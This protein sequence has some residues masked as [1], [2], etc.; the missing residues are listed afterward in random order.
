MKSRV[1]LAMAAASLLAMTSGL[2]WMASGSVSAH[3]DTLDGPV[4]KDA[5]VALDKGDV[6]PVLKWVP[7]SSEEEIEAAF[8]KTLAVRSKGAEAQ[9]LADRYFFET[10]VRVHRAGEGAPFTGLKPAGTAPEPAV[11]AADKALESGSVDAL[12]DLVARDVADGIR[13]RFARTVEK[14]KHAE[15]NVEAGR[16]Y[17][18]AYVD[19]VH[20]VEGIHA[21]AT[22]VHHHGEAE[23]EGAKSA[24]EHH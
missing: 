10:L 11:Q 3:C 18:A 7:K 9:E 4:V 1:C 15:H 23:V 16:E 2:L 17:V 5:K 24:H 6:K 14:K 12:V 8:K 21:A 13:R 22:S 19:Y 20:Y